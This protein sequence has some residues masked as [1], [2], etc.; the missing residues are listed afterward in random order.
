RLERHRAERRARTH[1]GG[2][3]AGGS[4]L[5]LCV[6]GDTGRGPVRA[7]QRKTELPMGR[8]TRSGGLEC[9]GVVAG[10]T[11]AGLPARPAGREPAAVRVQMAGAALDL[12]DLEQEGGLA[13]PDSGGEGGQRLPV[14][15]VA[16]AAVHLRV[17]TIQGQL[18]AAV[19]V[20]AVGARRPAGDRV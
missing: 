20:S 15:T 6:T 4:A 2:P 1:Q 13:G 14:A 7:L 5:H 16:G 9:A 11:A 17:A 8:H 10:E 12:G 19:T 3:G 18:E